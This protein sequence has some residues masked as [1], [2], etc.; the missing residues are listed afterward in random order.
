MKYKKMLIEC[1][2]QME[3]TSSLFHEDDKFVQVLRK[4]QA[5]VYGDKTRLLEAFLRERGAWDAFV[6]NR[7]TPEFNGLPEVGLISSAFLWRKTPE[8]A[9]Y[10]N[11]LSEAFDKYYENITV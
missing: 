3:Q 5:L 7:E 11:R 8:G 2:E 6:K 9:E 10:W 4:A 1:T